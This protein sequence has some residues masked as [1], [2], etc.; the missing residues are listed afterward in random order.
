MIVSHMLRVT[1]LVW[2]FIQ[3]LSGKGGYQ[4]LNYSQHSSS[5]NQNMQTLIHDEVEILLFGGETGM[6]GRD[7]IRMYIK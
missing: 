5:V 4:W 1:L 2:I 3:D 6:Y 7:Y